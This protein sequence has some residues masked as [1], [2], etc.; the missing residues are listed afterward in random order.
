METTTKLGDGFIPL[1]GYGTYQ[2]TDDQCEAGV[3]KA[4]QAGYNHIDTAQFYDNHDGIRRG[5]LK[6]GIDRSKIC[7]N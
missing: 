1:V 3:P 2:M 4:L 6:A 7:H 5:M